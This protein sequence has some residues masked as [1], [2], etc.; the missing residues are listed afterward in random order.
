[1]SVL[2][3]VLAGIRA[4]ALAGGRPP[5][6]VFD[7]DSTLLS[8][9]Q[10]NWAILNEF[11]GQPE[12]PPALRPLV[13]RLTASDMG[14]NIMEDIHRRGFEDLATLKQLR[15]FWLKR[16]FH[17]DYLHHDEPLPGA[18]DFVRDLHDAGGHVVYLTG[19]DEPGMGRGTRASLR[20]KG[21]PM[22]GE[23]IHLRLK[24]RFQD[25]GLAFKRSVLAELKR[26]GRVLTAAENEPANANM[27]VAEFPEATVLFIETVHSPNPPP[28]ADGIVRLKDFLR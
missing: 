26:M 22:D 15:K 28:L 11:A 27:F 18:V 4:A 13:E 24:P 2:S 3:Q 5:L 7:L 6:A 14:W 19:R 8:T 10:R 25:E 20:D 17:D 9:Q 21:F 23:R 1:M 16:F 12:T